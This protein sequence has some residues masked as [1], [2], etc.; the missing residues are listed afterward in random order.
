M[1][2]PNHSW[3]QT[4][5]C[6]GR[7]IIYALTTQRNMRVHCVV[8]CLAVLLGI[9][10]RVELVE[11]LVIVVMIAMVI[12][13]EIANTALEALVDLVSPGYS[14]LARIAKDCAAG[15][16]FVCAITALIVGIIVFAPRILSLIF[17]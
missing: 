8:A 12:A 16:V 11:W 9:V 15:A 17:G 13:L 10:F 7:G 14:E 4:F 6:A 2:A 1:S 5:L 3:A